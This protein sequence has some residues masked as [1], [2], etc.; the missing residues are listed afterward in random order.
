MNP[1]EKKLQ[2]PLEEIPEV[3]VKK[4]AALIIDEMKELIAAT[5][6]NDWRKKIKAASDLFDFTLKFNEQLVKNSKSIELVDC[7]CRLMQDSN[8]KVQQLVLEKLCD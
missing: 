6:E 1:K 3:R 2:T 8:S 4:K 7:I 5:Q